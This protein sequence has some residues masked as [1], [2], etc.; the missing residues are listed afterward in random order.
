MARNYKTKTDVTGMLE[1]DP[2]FGKFSSKD[3]E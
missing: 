2:E 1:R 3:E